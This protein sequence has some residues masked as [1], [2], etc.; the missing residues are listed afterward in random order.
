M[1]AGRTGIL[2]GSFDPIHLGHLIVA[3][4]VYEQMRL[5]RMIFIPAGQSPLK[6]HQPAAS[7]EDRLRMIE[8]AT[9][10]CPRFQV[11]SIEVDRAGQSFTVDTL[12]LLRNQ[13]G[14]ELFFLMGYDQVLDL[15]RWRDP[16]RILELA[17]I[18]GMSR[19]EY[20]AP[21]LDGLAERLPAIRSRLV[22]VHVPA[23]EISS[24]DLRRRLAEGRS[25]EFRVMPGVRD[26]IQA[27]GLYGAPDPRQK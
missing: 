9:E 19:P 26:Y 25:I 3:D 27:N 12:R 10:H 21:D 22:L 11:S 17:Q 23:I 2:G 5:D 18:V 6:K 24:T 15:H 7:G 14:D 20:Q 8:L 4:H 1:T 13:T 16:D